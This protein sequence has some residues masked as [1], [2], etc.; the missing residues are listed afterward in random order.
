MN[1][2]FSKRTFLTLAVIFAFIFVIA[3]KTNPGIFA[4]G[5]SGSFEYFRRG[6]KL[7]ERE[8]YRDAITYFQKAH[9]ASPENKAIGSGLVYAYSK[10]GLVLAE[11]KDYARAVEYLIKAYEI[12]DD[13]SAVQNLAI[14]YS[15]KAVFEVEK[16]DWA[17][18]ME[19]F[20]NARMVVFD[21]DS[22]SKALGLSLFNDAAAAYKSGRTNIAALCARESLLAYED[23]R[24]FEFAGDIY[25][26]ERDLSR[27]VFYWNKARGL[28]PDDK[29]L[30]EKID[31]LAREEE[32]A[33][34]ERLLRLAHFDIRYEKGLPI[35][36]EALG[37]TLREAYLDVGASLKYFPDSKTMVFFY[38]QK[39]FRELFNLP[40]AVRAFYDGNIR[41]PL[42]Q[43]PLDNKGALKRYIYHE[44]AHA[45]VSAKTNSNCPIWLNEGIAV[46]QEFKDAEPSILGV[47][48]KVGGEVNVSLALLDKA[49]RAEDGKVAGGENKDMGSYYLLAYSAVKYILD[50]WG[51]D[52][53]NGILARIAAGQHAANAIDDE[54][55]L[56]EK[57]FDKR[58]SEYLKK[59]KESG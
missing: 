27:A 17:G 43:E 13:I 32:L 21:S 33:G 8:K 6:E 52:G 19:D 48:A 37:E 38:S 49:F 23:A 26:K 35:D 57:E 54:L 7:L 3:V 4:R 1:P 55:L 46:W 24:V 45:V 9:D 42:P 11:K 31:R 5:T 25:Y 30:V 47:M 16:G 15:K 44:Y 28:D 22:A 39:T 53:L 10:Y 58:W 34:T 51:A 12:S 18:A 36:A 14:M 59:R 41:I 40:S 2:V 20:T 56:S 29:E 50:N